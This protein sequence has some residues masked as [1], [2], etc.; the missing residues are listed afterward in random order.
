MSL[1][2]AV[3]AHLQDVADLPDLSGTRYELIAPLGRGGMGCVYRVRDRELDR[4]VALK[5][6]AVSPPARAP[7]DCEP[8]RGCWRAS[9]TRASCRSTTPASCRT[10]ARST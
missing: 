8:K 1:S 3:V 5:V 2:D 9:S 4:E 6:S 7:S 10:D